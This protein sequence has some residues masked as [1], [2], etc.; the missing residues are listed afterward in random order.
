MSI[1]AQFLARL[2]EAKTPAK[3][4]AFD[5]GVEAMKKAMRSIGGDTDFADKIAEVA[6]MSGLSGVFLN[7]PDVRESVIEAAM[8]L[9]SKPARVR[10]FLALHS[11]LSTFHG[12]AKPVVAE[13]KEEDLEGTGFQQLVEEVLVALGIP[14]E[15]VSGE[16]KAGAKAGLKRMTAKL[17]A[18]EAV[19][20]AF[21]ALAKYFSIKV[22]DGAVGEKKRVAVTEDNEAGQAMDPLASAK[23]ILAALGVNLQDD[24]VIR[25]VNEAALT[26]AMKVA[27]R[28]PKTKVAIAAFI[29]NA[30]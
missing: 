22:N 20:A 7:K 14:A 3:S 9:R 26:R 23:K 10:A 27:I 19:R 2:N 21:V 12:L 13:A 11:A 4:F 16:A 17:R 6:A 5:R 18:D 15:L 24:K 1:G 28:N 30:E 25:V 8:A 29:R